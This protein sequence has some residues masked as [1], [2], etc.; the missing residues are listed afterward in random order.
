MRKLPAK[1]SS[2]INLLAL[3]L[4]RSRSNQMMHL[5]RYLSSTLSLNRRKKSLKVA[6][7]F[8]LKATTAKAPQEVSRKAGISLSKI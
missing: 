8:S 3:N 6:L 4:M 7:D 2:A 5:L 1:K